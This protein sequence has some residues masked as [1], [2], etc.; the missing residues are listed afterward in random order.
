M[1]QNLDRQS[2]SPF[3][4][5]DAQGSAIMV[6]VGSKDITSRQAV[7]AGEIML[8]PKIFEAVQNQTL[9]KGDVL[10]LA[11]A[12]GIMAVKKTSDLI[13][14]CHPLL[15][16]RCTINFE[17]N[18]KAASVKV[19]CQVATEGRTGVE[20]EALTGVSV[21]LLTIYDMCK[22]LDK[23]MVLSGIHLLEKSGGRSGIYRRENEESR[24]TL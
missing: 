12:A 4:H 16:N 5:L 21:A 18:S 3:S 1:N 13:P 8:G 9:A 7:A 6:D 2:Y 15:V 10:G 19:F 14:L 11:R 24:A 23:G 20:M 22:V 17:L